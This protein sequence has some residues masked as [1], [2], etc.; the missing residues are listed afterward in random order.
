MRVGT[1]G[2]LADLQRLGR[3]GMGEEETA[4]FLVEKYQEEEGNGSP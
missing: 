3:A 1:S 4:G 2:G